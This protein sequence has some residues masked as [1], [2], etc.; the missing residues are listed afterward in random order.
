[1]SC[2][3]IMTCYRIVK[4]IKTNN[5]INTNIS[6]NSLIRLIPV[7]HQKSSWTFGG[8][9]PTDVQWYF[10]IS[11]S[12]S[13]YIYICIP[14]DCHLSSGISQRIDACR[15]DFHWNCPVD[16]QWHF[17]MEFDVCEFWCVSI[18]YNIMI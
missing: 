3:Y 2:Y 14:K 10:Y 9:C 11:L 1:M 18:S 13:I 7:P 5:S 6:V 12:L 15:V 17:P 16:F 4:H 8:L